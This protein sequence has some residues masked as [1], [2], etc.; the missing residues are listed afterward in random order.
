MNVSLTAF[1]KEQRGQ[2]R[3][4]ISR[5]R[6]SFYSLRKLATNS[7]TVRCA[8]YISWTWQDNH[9]NSDYTKVSVCVCVCVCVYTSCIYVAEHT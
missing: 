8:D 2:Q 6:M 4:A 7:E 5:K 9:R 3:G 1:R